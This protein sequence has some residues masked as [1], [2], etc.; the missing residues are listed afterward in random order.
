[1]RLSLKTQF[2]LVGY[3]EAFASKL[4]IEIAFGCASGK[5]LVEAGCE[6]AA[7][8]FPAAAQIFPQDRARRMFHKNGIV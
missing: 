4:L 2:A 3:K 6:L 5:A 7:L 1:M 8:F